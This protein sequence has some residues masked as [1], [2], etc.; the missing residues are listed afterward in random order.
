MHGPVQEMENRYKLFAK[1]GIRGI[2]SYNNY[3]YERSMDKMPRILVIIDELADLMMVARDSVEEAINR[4]AQK[5]RAAGIHLG[6]RH[7][8]AICRRYHGAD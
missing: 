6:R 5:A 7:A 2:T 3:A 8:A 4:I 1:Y